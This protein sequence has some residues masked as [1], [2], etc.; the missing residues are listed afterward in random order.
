AKGLENKFLGK[1]FVF[2]HRRSEQI[3]NQVIARCHQCGEPCD[4]H[5]NCANEACHLLFIQCES[6]AKKMNN[7]CSTDCQDIIKLP[8]DEQKR[9]RAGKKNSNK[10][11]KKGRSPVLKFKV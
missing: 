3:S 1:N 2:D 7:C 9:L 6:C 11:F 10:I 5:V 4:T 8:Y